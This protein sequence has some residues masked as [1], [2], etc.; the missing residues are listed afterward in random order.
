VTSV[1]PPAGMSL[2]LILVLAAVALVALFMFS[3]R[4]D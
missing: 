4:K 1:D 3:G 2:I